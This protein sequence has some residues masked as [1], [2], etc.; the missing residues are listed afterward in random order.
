MGVM[1]FMLIYNRFKQ[2]DILSITITRTKAF[3]RGLR[4]IVFSILL[5]IILWNSLQNIND[6]VIGRYWKGSVLCLILGIKEA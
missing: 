3:G 2:K 1:H 5:S 4:L 6:I